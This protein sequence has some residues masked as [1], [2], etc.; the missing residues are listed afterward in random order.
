[1]LLI[2]RICFCDRYLKPLNRTESLLVTLFLETI[3]I[4]LFTVCKVFLYH[5][6]R[7]IRF[8][9]GMSKDTAILKTGEQQDA[10]SLAD[11]VIKKIRCKIALAR[12]E[13]NLLILWTSRCNKTPSLITNNR[14]SPHTA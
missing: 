2:A 14:R 1:M 8:I 3:R 12:L 6:R 5:S 4:Y 7:R 11:V 9:C 10:V 13:K